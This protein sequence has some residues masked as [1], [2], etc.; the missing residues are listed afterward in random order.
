[1][2]VDGKLSVLRRGVAQAQIRIR[3]VRPDLVA[4][5]YRYLIFG[6][7]FVS[8]VLAV[9]LL[10]DPSTIVIPLQG[11]TQDLSGGFVAPLW[12]RLSV[13][14]S[15]GLLA[16]VAIELTE[17]RRALGR[18]KRIGSSV[19]VPEMVLAAC[20]GFPALVLAA[21]RASLF[22]ITAVV[23][24]ILAELSFH[25]ARA[26]APRRAAGVGTVAVALPWG[27]VLVYQLFPQPAVGSHVWIALFWFAAILASFGAFYAIAQASES[28]VRFV[29]FRHRS[30]FRPSTLVIIVLVAAAVLVSR[31]TVLRE[32]FGKD[33]A[34]V[35]VPRFT[36]PMSWMHAVLVASL[37]AFVVYQSFQRPLRR[38]AERR[39][40]A[41]VAAVGTIDIWISGLVATF[42]LV[43]LAV[44]GRDYLPTAW[45][46]WTIFLQF[47]LITAL[48]AV[49]VLPRFRGTTGR[50]VALITSSY[51]VPV[52]FLMCFVKALPLWVNV[53]TSVQV[54]VV[55]LAIAV[56]LLIARLGHPKTVIP[57]P[58]IVSLAVVPL[59]VLHAGLLL[60]AVWSGAAAPFVVIAGISALT[61]FRPR[62]A[63]DPTRRAW[64]LLRASGALTLTFAIYALAPAFFQF[65]GESFALSGNLWLSVTVIAALTVKSVASD[66]TGM[67][68]RTAG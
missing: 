47:A 43:V 37:L 14:A 20:A 63:A 39:V 52:L 45:I 26:R 40:S 60:P 13:S 33:D 29:S 58:V 25:I 1:M 11:S 49:A 27:L 38:L 50:W 41:L 10:L 67:A 30:D 5:Q 18:N 61:L 8:A 44:W 54:A 17:L 36:A 7:W 19:V 56:A 34:S 31:F 64:D 53:T 15:I 51:L 9:V 55:L 48:G 23:L 22:A 16:V 68:D 46:E 4:V 32:V 35:W 59:V 42:G 24:F 21:D 65:N 6:C 62:V 66:T 28:R 12:F 3:R 2:P 57:S